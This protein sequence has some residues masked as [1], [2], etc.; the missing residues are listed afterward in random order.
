MERK[1]I[2]FFWPTF[3]QCGVQC[4][5]PARE[6]G[7]KNLQTKVDKEFFPLV[8]SPTFPAA[9]SPFTAVIAFKLSLLSS[10]STF[11]TD[12]TFQLVILSDCRSFPV[13]PHIQL[14]LLYCRPTSPAIPFSQSTV[15]IFRSGF[16]LKNLYKL[17]VFRRLLHNVLGR[18][19]DT[20][21]IA[22]VFGSWRHLR[23]SARARRS[24]G[25]RSAFSL[26]TVSLFQQNFFFA[27]NEDVLISIEVH[28]LRC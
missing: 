22:A 8:L 16:I 17:F 11:P 12:P 4:V 18:A 27:Q 3:G 19:V 13:V 7:D 24:W 21:D 1:N 26:C 6:R 10:C 9:P 25:M 14:S 20:C 23:F 15:L 2:L 5:P 28:H